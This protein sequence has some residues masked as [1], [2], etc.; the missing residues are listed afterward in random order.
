MYS[1]DNLQTN[2]S[3]RITLWVRHFCVY[4]SMARVSL[5]VASQ[6]DLCISMTSF[7]VTLWFEGENDGNYNFNASK[8]ELPGAANTRACWDVQVQET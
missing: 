4:G 3:K 7:Q 8:L 6:L 5:T 2:D 1:F